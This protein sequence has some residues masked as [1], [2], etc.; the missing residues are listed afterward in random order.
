[1]ALI[2]RR[3]TFV[4]DYSNIDDDC[5]YPI[6]KPV[7]DIAPIFM[8]KIDNQNLQRCGCIYGHGKVCQRP[9]HTGSNRCGFHANK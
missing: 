7:V 4:S 5:L 9:V 3:K 6:G 2:M 1:M 8:K